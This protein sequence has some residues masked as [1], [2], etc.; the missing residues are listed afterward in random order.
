[1]NGRDA[2]IRVGA[3]TSLRDELLARGWPTSIDVGSVN[4]SRA[5]N[6]GEWAKDKRDAGE[7]LGVWSESEHTYRHPIF[8]F[9]ANGHLD[10]QV[11]DLLSAMATVAE[12]APTNDVGGWHRAFWLHGTSLGLAGVDGRPAV[13]ADLFRVDPYRVISFA[14]RSTQDDLNGLW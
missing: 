7:L 8:Q 9:D 6:L 11:K 1:M 5:L 14:R 10:P 4:S 12:F 3:A 2:E 13:P